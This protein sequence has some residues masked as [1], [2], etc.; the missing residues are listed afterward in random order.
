M[1]YQWLDNISNNYILETIFLSIV[2][3]LFV[4]VFMYFLKYLI[5]RENER[6]EGQYE[7]NFLKLSQWVN[8]IKH[9][10]FIFSMIIVFIKSSQEIIA[11]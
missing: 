3:L 10:V 1:L 2:T 6:L 5:R 11:R 7:N 9:L 4:L 8:R